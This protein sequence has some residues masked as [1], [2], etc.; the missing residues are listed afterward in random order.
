MQANKKAEERKFKAHV[1]EIDW[2][3][4]VS[5]LVSKLRKKGDGKTK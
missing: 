1:R 4:V 3:S 2:T 5:D